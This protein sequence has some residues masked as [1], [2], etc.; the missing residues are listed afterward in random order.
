MTDSDLTIYA[1]T[2]RYQRCT[3]LI[4]LLQMLCRGE[5]TIVE[6]TRE[7]KCSRRTVERLLH[8]LKRLDVEVECAAQTRNTFGGYPPRLYRV[9]ARNAAEALGLL[10]EE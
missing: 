10:G 5:H 2:S 7:L 4:H 9:N 3:R 8:A 1:D 6:L